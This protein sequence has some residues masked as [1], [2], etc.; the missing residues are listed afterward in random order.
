M[1]VRRR[2]SIACVAGGIIYAKAKFSN[3][4]FGLFSQLLKLQFTAMVTYSFQSFYSP[5][6]FAAPPPKVC[7]ARE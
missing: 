7:L 6:V 3:L 4:F 5:L 2:G 1:L